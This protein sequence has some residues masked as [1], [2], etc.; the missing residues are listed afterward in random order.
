[1]SEETGEPPVKTVGFVGLGIMGR[2]MAENLLKAGYEVLVWNRT[3]SRCQPLV[4]QGASQVKRPSDLAARRP[5]VVC[6]NV[7]DTADVE[8]VLFGE[9]GIASGA[10]KGLVVVDF[11]TIDPAAAEDFASRLEPYGVTLVDA[12]VSGGDTGAEQGT[13]SVMVGGDEATVQRLQQ[14]LQVLGSKVTHMGP[15]GAGQA[16]KA[17]N[18]IAVACNLAG[19]CE[20]LA[21][22]R[23]T[24]LDLDKLIDVIGGGAGG[25]WQLENLGPK[26]ARGDFAPGFMI[27]LVLKDLGIVDQTAR[28]EQLPISATQAAE[29]YFRAAAARGYGRMGTQAMAK[30]LEMMGGFIYQERNP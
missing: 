3:A 6:L 24:G 7:T 2:P 16:C 23:E 29:Q 4:E 8:Q 26:M 22:G 1:L 28:R 27:D 30:A 19:V 15:V 10:K 9:T 25:S 17:C 14:M 21:L 5:D 11:S 20:A 12:P 18:Q 13:L